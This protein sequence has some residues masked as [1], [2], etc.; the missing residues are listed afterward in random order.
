ML[1]DRDNFG[2]RLSVQLNSHY[3]W[4]HD[5]WR[6]MRFDRWEPAFVVEADAPSQ[7]PRVEEEWNKNTIFL[8]YLEQHLK[9]YSTP[10]RC[11]VRNEVKV[12]IVTYT[13]HRCV[14]KMCHIS[15][16]GPLIGFG[17]VIRDIQRLYK[18]ANWCID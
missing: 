5:A 17:I 14:C 8:Q 7:A 16:E 10:L 11:L 15:N 3:L 4:S 18:T 6:D 13:T 12:T 9:V 1:H 2:S